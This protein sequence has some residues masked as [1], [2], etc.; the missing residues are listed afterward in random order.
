MGSLIT[1]DAGGD[2]GAS[3]D[4]L[5][6]SS[7]FNYGGAIG[8]AGSLAGGVFGFM[9]GMSSASKL[10]DAAKRNDV[11]TAIKLVQQ[12]RQG[13]Q[14]QGKTEANIGANG[15]TESGSAADILRMNAQ[16]LALDH[17]I[18]QNNGSEQSASLRS[19][20]SAASSGAWGSLV[21]GV[22]NGAASAASLA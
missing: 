1:D 6:N 8:A 16:N 7:G 14:L 21:S 12:D 5:G 19:K 11:A 22:L 9:S 2:Y 18:I 13:Y 4:L 3:T 20:A 15:I 17:G 10:R